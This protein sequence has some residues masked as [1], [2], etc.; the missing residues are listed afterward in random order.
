MESYSV[1]RLIGK[2]SY[3]EV[4]L[5]AAREGKK[6]VLGVWLGIDGVSRHIDFTPVCYEEH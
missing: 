2:G 3:G 4:F 6:K 1:K 5:V